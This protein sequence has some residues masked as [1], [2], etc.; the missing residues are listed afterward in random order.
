MGSGLY[1]LA[2]E[3]GAIV[4]AWRFG[5]GLQEESLRLWPGYTDEDRTG[6]DR[7]LVPA[8]PVNRSGGQGRVG[9]RRH[10]RRRSSVFGIG[11]HNVWSGM[12]GQGS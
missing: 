12:A 9:Y 4:D 6:Q 8:G 7:M 11:L 1:A 10:S 2:A 3:A 5:E